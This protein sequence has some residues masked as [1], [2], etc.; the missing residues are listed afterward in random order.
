MI[1]RK[2]IIAKNCFKI[3]LFLSLVKSKNE[4]QITKKMCN[5]IFKCSNFLLYLKKVLLTGRKAQKNARI[6]Q[7][8]EKLNNQQF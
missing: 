7:F 8:S 2:K 5:K 1:E 4:H 6:T 3:S